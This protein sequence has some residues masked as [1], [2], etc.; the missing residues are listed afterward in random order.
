MVQDVINK[1]NIDRTVTTSWWQS[2]QRCH[3]DIV[4]WQRESISQ[5]RSVGASREALSNYFDLLEKTL[6]QSNLI[7]QPC[8]IFNLDE[9]GLPFDPHPL[10]IICKKGQKHPVTTTTG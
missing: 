4:L 7:D 10:K 5:A 3:R 2:F 1:K 6:K 8:S 9:T